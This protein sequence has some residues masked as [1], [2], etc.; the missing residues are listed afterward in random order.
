[1]ANIYADELA[2]DVVDDCDTRTE[3]NVAEKIWIL[4]RTAEQWSSGEHTL[5]KPIL[6]KI[7]AVL[8]AMA[9]NVIDTENVMVSV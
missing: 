4:V 2:H 6:T 7:S 9:L 5:L 8:M 3:L 1:M